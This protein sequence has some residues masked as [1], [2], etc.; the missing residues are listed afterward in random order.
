[1]KGRDRLLFIMILDIKLIVFVCVCR[2]VGGCALLGKGSRYAIDIYDVIM[3]MCV[4]T[5]R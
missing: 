2:W 3:Y 4:Y 1:M 5:C